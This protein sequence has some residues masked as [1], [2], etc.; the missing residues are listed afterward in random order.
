MNQQISEIIEIM[1]RRRSKLA[2]LALLTAAIIILLIP[3]SPDSTVRL[4]ENVELNYIENNQLGNIIIQRNSIHPQIIKFPAYKACI[5]TNEEEP[6]VILSTNSKKKVFT[7]SKIEETTLNLTIPEDKI[8]E[9][10][11]QGPVNI[12]K[13]ERCPLRDQNKIVITEK[14]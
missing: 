2:V 9:K 3:V 8:G 12:T 5:Y 4:K 6:P 11:P 10:Y 13:R 14:K 7:N 1:E